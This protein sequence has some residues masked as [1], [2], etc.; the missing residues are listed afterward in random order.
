[1][2]G[3][4]KQGG[5]RFVLTCHQLMLFK[6]GG[7]QGK[8]KIDHAV[9]PGI[10]AFKRG[11]DVSLHGK[12]PGNPDAADWMPD[13]DTEC[14]QALGHDRYGRANR[15]ALIASMMDDVDCLDVTLEILTKHVDR[16]SFRYDTPSF[17]EKRSPLFSGGMSVVAVN[18]ESLGKSFRRSMAFISI[19]GNK[20][21]IAKFVDACL[22]LR[23]FTLRFLLRFYP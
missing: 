13:V 5:I 21:I 2:P 16:I 10:Y 1:M 14:G 9:G 8:I 23:L 19:K 20:E 7:T 4:G 22:R 3:V 15:A 17:Y 6:M 11:N 18:N 12:E